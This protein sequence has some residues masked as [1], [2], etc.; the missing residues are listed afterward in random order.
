MSIWPYIGIWLIVD[1]LA[2]LWANKWQRAFPEQTMRA[3]RLGIGLAM[4]GML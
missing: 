4:V 2:S 1:A 3:V